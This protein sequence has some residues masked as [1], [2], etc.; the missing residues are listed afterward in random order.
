MSRLISVLISKQTPVT[1]AETLSDFS[2]FFS[3]AVYIFVLFVFALKLALL[4]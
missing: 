3:D 2:L 1:I 4:L